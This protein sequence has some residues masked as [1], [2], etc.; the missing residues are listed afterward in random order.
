MKVYGR[1]RVLTSSHDL[2]LELAFLNGSLCGLWRRQELLLRSRFPGLLGFLVIA[3]S[4]GFRGTGIGVGGGVVDRHGSV[5]AD[6]DGDVDVG[7]HDRRVHVEV[8]IELQLHLRV[9]E[10]V[11]ERAIV[12]S[13]V[14]LFVTGS[15]DPGKFVDVRVR[16]FDLV[17]IQIRGKSK[18]KVLC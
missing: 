15:E 1:F 13:P 5:H 11:I 8:V 16:I 17:S 14:E 9:V 10:A 3:S 12:E 2:S 6:V 7:T 18:R 4:F